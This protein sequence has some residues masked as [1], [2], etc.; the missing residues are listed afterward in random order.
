[1]SMKL[2][3]VTIALTFLIAIQSGEIMAS[4]KIEV[5]KVPPELTLSG[6]EGG[7]LEKGP[8][9]SS[10]IRGKV[11]AL[12]HTDPDER[13]LNEHV[14]KVLKEKAFPL[15]QF[16]SIAVVNMAATWLPNFAIQSILEGKQ[17]EFPHTI[18]V[19]DLKKKFVAQWGLADHSYDILVFDREGVLR[20]IR[21]GKL[22][23]NDLE[24]MLSVITKY[25]Q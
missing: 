19:M 5:G 1:M 12:F 14:A 6:E 25:L 11:Y 8:W 2:Q 13:D 4:P 21:S 3:M 10:S 24:E 20:F 22:S 17:K 23:A 18:Y 16:G 9:S 7:N 15:D